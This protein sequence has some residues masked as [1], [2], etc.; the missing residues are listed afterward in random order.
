[1]IVF[2]DMDG[3]FLTT[4]KQVSPRAWEALDALAARGFEF[5]P[6]TGRSIAAL[7]AELLA[8]P[9]VH[10]A[11]CSNGAVVSK[12]NETH[13]DA[14]TSQVIRTAPLLRETAL[15]IWQIARKYDVT[16]DVFADGYTYLNR[17][18]YDRLDEIIEEPNMLDLIR[19]ARVPVD[20][21]PEETIARVGRL[22]RITMYWRDPAD[23]DRILEELHGIDGITVTRSFPTNIEVMDQTV[24]KGH[25]LTWLCGHLGI[26]VA[27]AVGFGDNIN[28]IPM[29]QMAGLGV[30]VANA[31]PET[32]AAANRVCASNDED[33]V[34]NTILE[35]LAQNDR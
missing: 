25:A 10:F 9:S 23:R 24:S 34:A 5:V 18:T 14:Q 7:P 15:A 33:G 4:D 32:Q 16:Y 17:Q 12:L 27:D 11:V 6:C 31:E 2:S 29:L 30:A 28:D 3:T 19:K 13:K 26:D 8:H 35:L 21:T 22:E 1:M 20:E